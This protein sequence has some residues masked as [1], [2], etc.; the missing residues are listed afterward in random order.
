MVVV[1]GKG[2][3]ALV[4][5]RSHHGKPARHPPGGVTW[6][7]MPLYAFPDTKLAYEATDN[8]GNVRGNRIFAD[9]D[10]VR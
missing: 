2:G 6:A 9:R 4:T 5:I 7:V 10:P 3:L 1:R 8:P